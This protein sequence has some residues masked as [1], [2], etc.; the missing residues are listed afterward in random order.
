MC[1]VLFLSIWFFKNFYEAFFFA[2]LFDVLYGAGI[3]S[4]HGFR[5]IFS[6]I[7]LALIFSAGFVK[8]KLRV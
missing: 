3:A 8:G 6:S 4:L 1:A 2:F 5:F 7:F